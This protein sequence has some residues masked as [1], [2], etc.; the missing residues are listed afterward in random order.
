MKKSIILT[1]VIAT[2]AV[3]VLAAGG[4]ISYKNIA[5]NGS[6]YSIPELDL[7]ELPEELKGTEFEYLYEQSTV[8]N[9]KD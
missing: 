1:I 8:D 9:S 5:F 3:A 4:Y 6:D 2:V 7:S